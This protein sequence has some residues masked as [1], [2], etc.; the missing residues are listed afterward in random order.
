MSLHRTIKRSLLVGGGIGVLLI[1]V[2]AGAVVRAQGK[3]HAA[4]AALE[5]DGRPVRSA[6]FLPPEV[7]AAQNAAVLYRRA[8]R[9]LRAVPVGKT[10][11]LA[12]LGRLSFSYIGGGLEPNQVARLHE[13]LEREIVTSALQT[14][15]EARQRP[16]C[17]FHHDCE[18]G[19]FQDAFPADDLRCLAR[20]W[21]ART[22]RETERGEIGRVRDRVCA[23]LEFIHALRQD[24]VSSNQIARLGMICDL[25]R[26]LQRLCRVAPLSPEDYQEMDRQLQDLGDI[27][28]L[29]HALDA[30]RLLQGEWVFRLPEEELYRWLKEESKKAGSSADLVFRLR[31]RLLRCK[32]MYLAEHALYLQLMRK[33]TILLQG[34]YPPA[35]T[36]LRRDIRALKV[37]RHLLTPRLAPTFALDGKYHCLTEALLHVTRAGLGLLQYRDLHGSFPAALGDLTLEGLTDPFTQE[38]L[39]YGAAGGGF[40]VYSVGEDLKDDRRDDAPPGRDKGDDLLWRFGQETGRT[41]TPGN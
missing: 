18:G 10:T 5:R 4:Y 38:P 22:C 24:P 21:G 12:H 23:Q 3:L 11:L 39:H 19:V 34:P 37:G 41:I 27:E 33:G 32:P 15:E 28:P 16:D 17:Q 7:P 13:L 2:Y 35:D 20:I 1:V 6:D 40:V 26:V 9:A 29:V 30:E 36:G 31:F 25:C 14:M 8:A